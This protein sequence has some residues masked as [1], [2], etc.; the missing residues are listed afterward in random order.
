MA[1][2]P[3][4]QRRCGLLQGGVSAGSSSSGGAGSFKAA[5]VQAP[6]TVARA[7]SFK[8]ASVRAPQAASVRAPSRQRRRGLLKQWRRWGA[9]L[10]SG[11]RSVIFLFLKINFSCVGS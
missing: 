11:P 6:Q 7:G 5:S 10:G 4:R 2:A 9:G 8:V 3:A 1:R